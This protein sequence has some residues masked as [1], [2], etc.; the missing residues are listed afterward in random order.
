MNAVTE[1]AEHITE[2]AY[3]L[4]EA[5]ARQL[6][7]HHVT[8]S[9]AAQATAATPT[10]E[11]TMTNVSEILHAIATHAERYGETAL[12]DLVSVLGNPAAAPLIGYAAR[13]LELPVT[14]TEIAIASGGLRQL[15]ADVQAQRQQSQQDVTQLPPGQTAA[16]ADSSDPRQRQAVGKRNADEARSTRWPGVRAQDDRPSANEEK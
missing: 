1:A 7:F 3:D 2:H 16:P 6:G 11:H 10:E 5:V 8:H 14:P 12:A 4:T 15:L 13:L 9:P